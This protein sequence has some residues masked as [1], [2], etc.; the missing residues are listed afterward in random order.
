MQQANEAVGQFAH[1]VS[2]MAAKEIHTDTASS[3]KISAEIAAMPSEW[4]NMDGQTVGKLAERM[5]GGLEQ[6]VG[7]LAAAQQEQQKRDEETFQETEMQHSRRRRR[8]RTAS[9]GMGAG[10][11]RKVD[12]DIKADDRTAGQGV[13]RGSSNPA[14]TR[15]APP[16]RPSVQLRPED[17]A[18]VQ[19]M[20]DS[21]RTL[22][23]AANDAANAI[24]MAD[25]KPGDKIV[26]DDQAAA[27][28]VE[29]TRERR[30]RNAQGNRQ[31]N[32][33]MGSGTRNNPNNQRPTRT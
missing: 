31:S 21:L 23:N 25:V 9:S 14:A 12:Q 22:S 6:A 19:T 17:M 5:E 15:G 32:N 18:A 24:T 8:R 2:V 20:S 27:A 7:E 33:P 29:Q 13:F 26:P 11:M 3:Q 10:A 4:K 30:G 1:A 28:F 16:A